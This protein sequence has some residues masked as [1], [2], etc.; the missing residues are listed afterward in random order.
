MAGA[1]VTKVSHLPSPVCGSQGQGNEKQKSREERT[2]PALSTILRSHV[3]DQKWTVTMTTFAGTVGLL[4]T[5]LGTAQKPP[6]VG[7]PARSDR[8]TVTV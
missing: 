5:L 7:T 2:R 1:Y 8:D 4:S 6:N 3:A